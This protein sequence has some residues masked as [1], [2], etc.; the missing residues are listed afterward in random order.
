MNSG[1][2]KIRGFFALLNHL[3]TS[4]LQKEIVMRLLSLKNAVLATAAVGLFSFAGIESVNAQNQREYRDWQRAQREAEQE[5]REY[6]RT[7]SPRDYREWQRAQREAQR[8]LRDYRQEVRED[9]RDMSRAYNTYNN[10][11]YGSYRLYRNG[12]YYTIDERGANLL[13]QAVNSGYQ[14][15]YQQGAM[16]RRYGRGGSYYNS[17]VYRSGVYGWQSSVDRSQYQYYFQQG[18]QRGYEDGYNSQMRYGYRSGNNF[19]IL[20]GILNTILNLTNN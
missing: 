2:L 1:H 8:E 20:G 13:R 10:R 7:R 4:L 19:N 15:G 12:R 3:T 6:M 18:F 9:R 17:N 11:S 16:D 14:Q 5:R